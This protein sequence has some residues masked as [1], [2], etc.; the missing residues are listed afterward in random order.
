MKIIVILKLYYLNRLISCNYYPYLTG[1]ST[2]KHREGNFQSTQG[3][4]VPQ[5]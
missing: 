3:V 1:V 2:K 4:K 5:V